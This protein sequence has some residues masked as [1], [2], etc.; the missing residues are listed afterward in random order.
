[1]IITGEALLHV[2]TAEVLFPSSPR[3]DG[4]LWT[5]PATCPRGKTS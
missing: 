4:G 1:M 3:T 2:H 5:G